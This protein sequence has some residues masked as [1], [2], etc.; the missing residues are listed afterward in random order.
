MQFWLERGAAPRCTLE[1]L[2][3]AVFEHHTA[4]CSEEAF[5][6][7]SGA[8]W[9]VQVKEPESASAEKREVGFHW[10]KD[11]RFHAAYGFYLY[12]QVMGSHSQTG[13]VAAASCQE[14]LDG[15]IKKHELTKITFDT[16]SK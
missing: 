14:Y 1:A 12:R 11:E 13:L 16:E 10:D 8:E 4:A 6:S 9:W 5:G 2:A 7:Q 15:I 3:A